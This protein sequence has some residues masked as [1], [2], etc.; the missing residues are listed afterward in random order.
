M[1]QE[2]SKNSISAKTWIK[3]QQLYST[4]MKLR[5]SFELQQMSPSEKFSEFLALWEFAT[6]ADAA[7]V[8]SNISFPTKIDLMRWERRTRVS[9]LIAKAELRRKDSSKTSQ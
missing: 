7:S 5:R 2:S 4:E 8:N 6:K 9:A 3:R 1:S